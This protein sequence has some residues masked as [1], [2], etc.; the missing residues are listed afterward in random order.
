MRAAR[1]ISANTFQG[2]CDGDAD[3]RVAGAI[4]KM[5]SVSKVAH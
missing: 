3:A 1:W 4:G 2:L 5:T